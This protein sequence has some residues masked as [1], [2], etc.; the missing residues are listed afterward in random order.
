MEVYLPSFLP[1]QETITDRPTSQIT[2]RQTEQRRTDMRVIR[3]LRFKQTEQWKNSFSPSSY[4]GPKRARQ[5]PTKP[6]S[7]RLA[8]FSTHNTSTQLKPFQP[9][10]QGRNWREGGG[11]RGVHPSCIVS[12]LW[13]RTC[14]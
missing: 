10:H 7:H 1:F 9:N 4:S 8:L 6:V 2:Y 12:T 3:K 13:L 5:K 14:L 11:A